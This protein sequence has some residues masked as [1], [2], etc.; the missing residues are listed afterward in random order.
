MRIRDNLSDRTKLVRFD[1]KIKFTATISFS[2]MS[3]TALAP[4]TGSILQ[5]T[6]HM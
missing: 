3:F 1:N 6:Y 2:Q 4:L 5:N